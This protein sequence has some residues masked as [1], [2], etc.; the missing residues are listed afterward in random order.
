MGGAQHMELSQPSAALH[1]NHTTAAMR[2]IACCSRHPIGCIHPAS[3]HS[4]CASGAQAVDRLRAFLTKYV[5]VLD[6]GTT[7]GLLAGYGRLD[8]LVHYARARGDWEGLLEHLLQ[9]GEVRLGGVWRSAAVRQ[10]MLCAEGGRA[11][12]RACP[13]TCCSAARWV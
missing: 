13:S 6:P 8:E 11:A 7:V 12:G 10:R 2:C 4:C 5:E 3:R 1:S 9:R